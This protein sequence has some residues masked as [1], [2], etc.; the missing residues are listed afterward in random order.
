MKT[1]I[2]KMVFAIIFLLGNPVSGQIN[3]EGKTV[4]D[5]S[6]TQEIYVSKIPS[7]YDMYNSGNHLIIGQTKIDS[8]GNWRLILPTPEEPSLIRIHAK[9][10]GDPISS[11][12]IGTQ[13]ENHGFLA[14]QDGDNLTYLNVKG[15]IFSNYNTQNSELNRQLKKIDSIIGFWEN[16][17]SQ[18]NRQKE[19]LAIRTAAA[20]ELLFIADTTTSILPA[21]YAAHS[22]NFGF[23]QEAIDLTMNNIKDKY[24]EHSYLSPYRI[25]QSNHRNLLLIFIGALLTIFLTYRF[26]KIYHTNKLRKLFSS[27]S[28]R[29]KDVFELVVQGKTNK[30][31]GDILNIETTTVK[32]HI[33]NIFAKL[34]VN[35]RKDLSKF[36]GLSNSSKTTLL[37]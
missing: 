14:I 36:I 4:L 33:K 27:L 9:K 17:D 23:N 35:S 32:S 18:S 21:I 34:E 6:W 29:E 8:L 11:L 5:S 22:A 12:V 25:K 26:Y 37:I 28:Y 7:L 30:E 13:E 3:I 10:S 20:K 1:Q 31:I 16:L 15:R 24:G 19:K 2:A